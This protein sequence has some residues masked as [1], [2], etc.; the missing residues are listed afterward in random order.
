MKA[1]LS[2]IA[3]MNWKRGLFR[4]WVVF[5]AVWYLGYGGAYLD[6][7]T[8][9]AEARAELMQTWCV[10]E[11][12]SG[13]IGSDGKPLRD[14]PRPRLVFNRVT[15]FGWCQEQTPAYLLFE[16]KP[17]ET[18]LIVLVIL[19]PFIFLALSAASFFTLRWVFSGFRAT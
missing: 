12:L 5:A 10:S 18:R 1:I 11:D 6:H 17:L 9:A 7:S 3:L 13:W 4:V 16:A 19:A 14:A 2:K 8:R 15:D